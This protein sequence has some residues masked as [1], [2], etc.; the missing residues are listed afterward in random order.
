MGTSLF[1]GGHVISLAAPYVVAT[2][3]QHHTLG[4]GMALAPF[5]FVLAAVIWWSLPETLRS[6]RL[7]RGFR[8]EAAR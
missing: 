6:S 4:V 8:A 3:S 1:H 5:T 2:V 7:Y